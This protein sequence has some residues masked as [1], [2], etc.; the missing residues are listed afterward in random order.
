MSIK[1]EKTYTDEELWDRSG[2]EAIAQVQRIA[3][4][5]VE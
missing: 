1:V 3:R 2:T 5:K 4:T